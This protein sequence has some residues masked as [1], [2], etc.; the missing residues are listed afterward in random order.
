MAIKPVKADAL[1]YLTADIIDT[2][3]CFTTRLGGVSAG[4]LDSLNLGYGRGDTSEN[5]RENYRRLG[6][7][8][9]FSPEQLVLAHQM[10]SDIVRV[11]TSQDAAGLDHRNYPPCDALIT[12][13][14]GVGLVV[15]TADCTPILLYDPEKKAVGAI[16][17]GWRGTAAGI[18][19]KAVNAM[20]STYGCN[21][22]NIRAAIGPNISQ[23]C[24][25]T[26]RD[27]PD[28]IVAALGATSAAP[29]IRQ[30]GNKFYVNLKALNAHFLD[31]AGVTSI[32]ISQACTACES[33]TYWS[34]RV[35]GGKRGAQGA[36]IIL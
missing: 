1:E 29:F 7:A 28:A 13:E 27:V 32:E 26:D 3:H 17:A 14:P 11:V 24:F 22:K 9:G 30:Q 10:H 15:F 33:R 12:N 4:I 25:E 2:P 23:C 35:T 18:A 20:V 6:A 19:E 34:H 21:P 5:I 8:V 31:R 16:H 36:I